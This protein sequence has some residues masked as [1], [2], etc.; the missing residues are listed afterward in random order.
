MWLH[1][2]FPGFACGPDHGSLTSG[3]RH[4]YAKFAAVQKQFDLE[5]NIP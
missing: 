3:S 5:T 1:G 2:T 4:L